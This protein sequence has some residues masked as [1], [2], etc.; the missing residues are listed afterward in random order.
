MTTKTNSADWKS[1]LK[2]D[3]TAWLLEE[4]NPSVRYF[5]LRDILGAAEEDADV[6]A[7]RKAVMSSGIVPRILEKQNRDGSWG[8]PADF[9]LRCKYRGTVWTII[10]LAQ[11]GADG[12]DKRIQ[13]AAEFIL[14]NSQ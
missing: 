11:L 5:T 4:S 13:K 1:V 10:L 3:P 2:A 14:A 12:N 7:A 6:K 9:Y 8:I